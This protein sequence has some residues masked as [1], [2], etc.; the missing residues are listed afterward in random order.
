MAN[1]DSKVRFTGS[2]T[3]GNFTYN[4][5]VAR[6]TTTGTVTTGTVTNIL[7]V[8]GN[9]RNFYFSSILN[10]DLTASHTLCFSISVDSFINLFIN[11]SSFTIAGG[12]V[13]AILSGNVMRIA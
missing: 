12:T 1:M 6:G 11:F 5:G 7:P 13:T 3:S 8:S 2:T 9:I 10:V 4:L